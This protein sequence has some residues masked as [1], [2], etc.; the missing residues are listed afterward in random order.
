M[1]RWAVQGMDQGVIEEV[2]GGASDGSGSNRSS[3]GLC[4]LWIR[5]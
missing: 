3:D 1:E 5:E 2:M 4:K